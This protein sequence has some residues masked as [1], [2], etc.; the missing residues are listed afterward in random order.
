MRSAFWSHIPVPLRVF[1]LLI[2]LAAQLVGC[3][4][5]GGGGGASNFAGRSYLYSNGGKILALT[6]DAASKF[7]A[8][9]LDP[10]QIAT[11]NGIQGTVAGNGQFTG[12]SNDGIVQIQGAV[13]LDG[14][15][16]NGTVRRN[17][18]DVF[19]FNAT[20]STS[21][22]VTPAN[23]TGSFSGVSGSDSALLSVD[24]NGHGVLFAKDGA[25][26]GGGLFDIGT[27]GDI[28]AID[29]SFTGT[30]AVVGD[31]A[32]LHLTKLAG[33]VVDFTIDISRKTKARWTF[34]VYI[35]AANNLQEFGPLN[36]NQME[37]IGSTADVNIVVQWKQ[38]VCS[39]CGSPEW[40]GTRRYF[41]TR[42]NNTSQVNSTLVE[43]MGQN[44]DMG[45]WHELRNFIVWGQQHYPADRT[46]VVIWN[47]GA[48]WRPTR[49]EMDRK[50]TPF[51]RSVSIDDHTRN[52]IQIWQLPQALDVSPKPDMVVFDASLMQMLEVAYEIKDST[53]VVVGSE[54]SPPG[55]GY[56]YDTFLNDLVQ[57]PTMTA[58]QFGTKIV[59][60]TLEAYGPNGNN[61]QS[62]INTSQ[63][64]NLAAKADAFA[65]SLIL[66]IPNSGA[67]TVTARN[68]A[69]SYAY[70]ENKDFWHYAEL[71]KSNASANDLKQAA[72]NVQTAI[73]A[74]VF[75]EGHGTLHRNSHGVAI[76]VPSPGGFLASYSNL[77]FARNT[78]WDQWLQTQP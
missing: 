17:A 76:Y 60:R 1:P 13:G 41:V 30:F 55:E 67:A 24:P 2:L 44:I 68:N 70:P 54:E 5:G 31:T 22:R 38:A 63:L 73:Q 28:D 45:D 34:L 51:P 14:Q 49:A 65:Q 29:S 8:F 58:T 59:T 3:G 64:A 47:H 26:V 46:S 37:K 11:G 62:A 23:L 18:V 36:V 33:Q 74:A 53:P 72:T 39:D 12:Q 32:T 50:L 48:G 40:T 66:N 25:V 6:I 9:V 35:N 42:D 15:I 27:T 43:D 4:G 16:A 78:S 21:T 61:T 10:G 52:E 77:A 7:T 69:D 57:T 20:V 56:V 71:V 75:A 19:T